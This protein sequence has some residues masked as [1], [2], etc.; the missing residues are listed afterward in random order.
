MEGH[1][2]YVPHVKVA[3][4]GHLSCWLLWCGGGGGY[5]LE[6]SERR[7]GAVKEALVMVM[8][9]RGNRDVVF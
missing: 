4:F 6:A 1:C 3:M 2:T 8:V 7:G 9:R 5:A